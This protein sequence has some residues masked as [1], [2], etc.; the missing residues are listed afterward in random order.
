LWRKYSEIECPK[1]Q[2][3]VLGAIQ[4]FEIGIHGGRNRYHI[5][6]VFPKSS[7]HSGQ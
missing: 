7:R 3:T 6:T 1:H 4:M 5:K 2:Q